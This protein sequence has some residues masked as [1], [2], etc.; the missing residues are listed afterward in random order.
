MIYSQNVQH[1]D[2]YTNHKCYYT[3]VTKIKTKIDFSN[4]QI[5]L[6]NTKLN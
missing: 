2:A 4:A 1:A 3:V 5:L 6:V